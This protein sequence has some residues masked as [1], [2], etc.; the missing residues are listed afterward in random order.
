MTSYS[1]LK[2]ELYL[3]EGGTALPDQACVLLGARCKCGYVFFPMQSYGC[4]NCGAVGDAV[5]SEKLAGSGHLIAA[6]KVHVHQGEGRQAP[7]IVVA[8][9]LDSGPVVRTLLDWPEN[10]EPPA[11]GLRVKAVLRPVGGA[12][13]NVLDLRFRSEAE[14]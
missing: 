1:L 3:P 8:V 12:Q 11:P 4:E 6:A 2:P 14:V 7:F 10:E 5:Q 13:E 9:R